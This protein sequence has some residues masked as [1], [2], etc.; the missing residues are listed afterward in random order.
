MNA[1]SSI[2]NRTSTVS[3]LYMSRIRPKS[4]RLLRLG[5]LFE[6]QLF[7]V[8]NYISFIS[9]FADISNFPIRRFVCV[10]TK[11]FQLCSL[12]PFP[13]SLG[14]LPLLFHCLWINPG[15]IHS[16]VHYLLLKYVPMN[17]PYSNMKNHSLQWQ[18]H[19]QHSRDI[20]VRLQRTA[21]IFLYTKFTDRIWGPSNLLSTAGIR[22]SA[23]LLGT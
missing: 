18:G 9:L 20:G 8:R 19:E 22:S 12:S 16:N 4:I 2:H 14:C 15:P 1:T 3:L 23:R 7:Q 11:P 17:A 10:R 6:E 13:L 5:I 21:E